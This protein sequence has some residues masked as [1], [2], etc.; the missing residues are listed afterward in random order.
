MAFL[1]TQLP[2]SSTRRQDR[3]LLWFSLDPSLGT[4][5]KVLD[6]Q[7][8]VGYS[9]EAAADI[10]EK[11]EVLGEKRTRIHFLLLQGPLQQ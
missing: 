10:G 6:L 8:Q 1:E 2:S 7:G 4:S 11:P 9:D 5:P 3:H